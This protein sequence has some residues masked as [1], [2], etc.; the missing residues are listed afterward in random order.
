MVDPVIKPAMCEAVELHEGGSAAAYEIGFAK[1]GESGASFGRMQGD[2]AKGPAVVKSTF[3]KVLTA[4][5]VEPAE[6]DALLALLGKPL[7]TSPLSATQEA[8]INAALSST[9]G[10]KLVDAMDDEL[11][12]ITYRR[13]DKCLTAA[14]KHG[15]TITPK[16]QCYIAM[17]SNM[18][19][20]PDMLAGWLEGIPPPLFTVPPAEQEVD[21]AALET[22]LS[23]TKYYTEHPQ[24]MKHLRD[25]AAKG[26]EELPDGM[27]TT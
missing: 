1:K 7:K 14:A 13:V 4:A 9:E 21:G 3:R 8:T 19:G 20:E 24:N 27:P 10:Q 22:Y 18:T 17:W 6:I 2:L 26:V 23:A 12:E 5:G 15:R 25:C 11:T 16:A